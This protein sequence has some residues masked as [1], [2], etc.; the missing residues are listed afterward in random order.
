[1]Q[2]RIELLKIQLRGMST[3]RVLVQGTGWGAHTAVPALSHSQSLHLAEA[4]LLTHALLM[5]A[6]HGLWEKSTLS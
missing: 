5:Q 6:L 4:A 3:L 2:E 1:M